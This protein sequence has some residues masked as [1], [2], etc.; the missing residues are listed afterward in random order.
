MIDFLLQYWG[1]IAAVLLIGLE[2][3]LERE[4]AVKRIRD[5]IFMAEEK[6]R[7]GVLKTGEDKFEWVVENG[8]KYLPP[9]LKVILTEE[10]FRLLVQTIFDGI[11]SWAEDKEL[12]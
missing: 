5:L 4:A 9:V 7:K 6:A 12:I 8:Y 11:M 3:I 1:I 2:L 10:A